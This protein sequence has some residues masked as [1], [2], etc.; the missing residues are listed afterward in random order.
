[1]QKFKWRP[2]A[3][4]YIGTSHD[5]PK[6]GVVILKILAPTPLHKFL[7][8]RLG[9]YGFGEINLATH[10]RTQ[11]I[12]SEISNNFSNWQRLLTLAISKNDI[13]TW[14]DLKFWAGVIFYESLN[15][16]F[17]ISSKILSC[18]ITCFTVIDIENLKFSE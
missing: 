11:T 7:P 16:I 12:F 18:V 14:Q 10:T 5:S 6:N 15:L 1:M 17:K 2:R 3:Q 4:I 8:V 9:R 13:I